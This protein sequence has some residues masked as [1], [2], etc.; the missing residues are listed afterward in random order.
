M[1]PYDVLCTVASFSY[2]HELFALML[3]SRDLQLECAK[4][5]LQDT[6][7]LNSDKGIVSFIYFMCRNQ[8][9]RWRFLRSLEFGNTD[10]DPYVAAE[11]G[12]VISR[13]SRLEV[14]SFEHAEVTL[15]AHPQL[16]LGLAAIS[17]IKHIEL[18]HVAQH[19]CRML[20]AMSWPLETACLEAS[21][22]D[23]DWEDPNWGERM[24]PAALLKN[25]RAT[26][27]SFKY[28]MWSECDLRLPQYPVY[29]A[30]YALHLV[31][32]WLPPTSQWPLTYPN[33][34]KLK[35]SSIDGGCPIDDLTTTRLTN[36][37]EYAEFGCWQELEHF[38]GGL[39]DLYALGLPCRILNVEISVSASSVD[40]LEPA[41][42]NA[43]PSRL[44]IRFWDRRM[45]D[46]DAPGLEF[47]SH[48]RIP[49]MAEVRTMQLEITT[50]GPKRGLDLDP[51]LEQVYDALSPLELHEFILYVEYPDCKD[52]R[53]II[54]S[55]A[56]DEDEGVAVRRRAPTPCALQIWAETA[57]ARA[58]ASR[59]F[60]AVR[61]LRSFELIIHPPRSV[62]YRHPFG[63]AEWED[64][65][66]I[67]LRDEVATPTL[68]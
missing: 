36:V 46:G 1:L 17:S 32:S 13:A 64:R 31:D 29:P 50:A 26:L 39:L 44:T 2:R 62:R 8:R 49:G 12:R 19:A 6:V 58:L 60:S 20:E 43:R 10:L 27:Q 18:R 9:R 67:V 5:I 57:D 11:L 65:R 37:L 59:A 38:S 24:H 23:Q 22:Y 15:G 47:P 61:S 34:R 16:G 28:D 3:A 4:C 14:L 30:L 63:S 41:L 21:E 42:S 52:R 7:A 40:A 51:F 55:D 66:T 68:S 53:R 56:S 54:E 48:L 33:L 35:V 25:S 45:F